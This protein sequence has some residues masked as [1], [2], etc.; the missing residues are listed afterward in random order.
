MGFRNI[1][2]AKFLKIHFKDHVYPLFYQLYILFPKYFSGM[3][4]V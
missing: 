4:S 2:L 3:R 1:N